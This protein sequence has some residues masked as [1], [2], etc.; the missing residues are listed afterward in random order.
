MRTLGFPSSLDEPIFRWRNDAELKAHPAYSAAKAGD[1]TA[2]IDL[3]LDLADPL[4]QQV[5]KVLHARGWAEPL[6]FVAPH[7]REARGDNAIPQVLAVF[8]SFGLGEVDERIVQTTKVYHTGA[9]AME[10]LIA[11]ASFQGP[12]RRGGNYVLVDDVTTLGGTLCDLSDY[13]RRSGGNVVAACVL[14]NASRS[15]KL[16]PARKIVRRLEEQYGHVIRQTFRIE[17]TALT[18]DEA[19]YLIGFRTAEEI[20]G[21]SAKAR[22]KTDLRLRS[23]GI[24][25][26]R[27]G[28]SPRQ[29]A[30][31]RAH[32]V[33]FPGASALRTARW[34]KQRRGA[35]K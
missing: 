30:V 34:I 33:P 32:R 25:L 22:E 8:L 6:I 13:I 14:V 9:D 16:F 19:Q 35:G 26:D 7:A 2:A 12:V 11:R 29:G 5:G 10:R 23:K 28:A 1:T 20:R 31:K 17:P 21:R 4:S 15:G 27:S 3:I 24:F 18:A